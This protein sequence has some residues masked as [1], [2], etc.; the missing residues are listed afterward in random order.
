MTVETIMKEAEQR[1]KELSALQ[2]LWTVTVGKHTPSVVQFN[3]WLCLHSLEDV[4]EGVRITG[5][6]LQMMDGQ[7]SADHLVRFT[8]SV[9]NFRKSTRESG[10]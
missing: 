6:K 1:E 8:S 5:K 3:T 4:V 7:M 10:I 2:K 9:M